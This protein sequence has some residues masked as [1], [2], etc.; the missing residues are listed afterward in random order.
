MKRHAAGLPDTS[1]NYLEQKQPTFLLFGNVLLLRQTSGRRSSQQASSKLRMT[2]HTQHSP[3]LS[4][5]QIPAAIIRHQQDST[6]SAHFGFASF[7]CQADQQPA[8]TVHLK[9]EGK[10]HPG[11]HI[12]TCPAITMQQLPRRSSA[13]ILLA[14]VGFRQ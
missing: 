4:Q 10:L 11:C 5:R 9:A 2:A 1:G 6:C 8:T 13:L 12:C 14:S 7:A 3:V